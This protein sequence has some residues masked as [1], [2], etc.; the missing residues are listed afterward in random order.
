MGRVSV[1][2]C[3]SSLRVGGRTELAGWLAGLML[4]SWMGLVHL[5]AR[6]IMFA[7]AFEEVSSQRGDGGSKKLN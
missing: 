2:G 6:S 4:Y 5:R 7:C 3:S 1:A